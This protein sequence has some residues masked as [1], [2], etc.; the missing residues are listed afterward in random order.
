MR[1]KRIIVVP[2]MRLYRKYIAVS[3]ENASSF[4]SKGTIDKDS[5]MANRDPCI[6]EAIRS[7]AIPLPP[8]PTCFPPR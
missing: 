7:S 1:F 3:V 2:V 6:V 5:R 8:P 4:L